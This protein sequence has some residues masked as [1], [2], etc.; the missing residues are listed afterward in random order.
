M[1]FPKLLV[2]YKPRIKSVLGIQQARQNIES[3]TW[4]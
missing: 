4:H 2:K 1:Q 3:H